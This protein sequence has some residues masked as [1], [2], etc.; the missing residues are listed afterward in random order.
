[1]PIKTTIAALILAAAPTF[2]FAMGCNWGSHTDT[3]ASTCI[4][5][6]VF[7]ETTGTCVPVS[8]S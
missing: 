4:D 8:T 7:D 6:Q 1:M 2:S 5:G 3:T